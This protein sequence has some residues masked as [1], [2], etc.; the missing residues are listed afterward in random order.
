MLLS[1]N[2]LNIYLRYILVIS[3]F[4]RKVF[5]TYSKNNHWG[6][7]GTLNSFI[8]RRFFFKVKMPLQ[9]KSHD[10]QNIIAFWRLT[11]FESLSF[12][13]RAACKQKRQRSICRMIVTGENRITLFKTGTSAKMSIT[14]LTRNRP[15]SNPGFPG[16]RLESNPWGMAEKVTRILLLK[17]S[18]VP[19]SK[20]T[21]YGL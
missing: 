1:L 14:N 11:G 5:Q 8:L 2:L 10:F 12:R 7:R 16:D 13:Q 17:Y 19:R 9:T 20:H 3:G 21:V 4:L 6:S 15:G 18:F